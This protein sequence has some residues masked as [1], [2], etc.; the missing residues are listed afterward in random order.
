MYYRF[1]DPVI[2]AYN[3]KPDSRD[4]RKISRVCEGIW[5]VYEEEMI[6]NAV[7]DFIEYPEFLKKRL[8]V[9]R[10]S[11]YV[12]TLYNNSAIVIGLLYGDGDFMQTVRIATD[13]GFDTDCN[14]GNAGAIIGAY[15]GHDLI[16]S[17][18]KRFIR[19]EIIPGL[20][21]WSDKSLFKLS[22]RTHTQALRFDDQSDL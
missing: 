7:S 8:S 11:K 4:S 16:P 14:A 6:K 10:Y 12:H 9:T 17:Y 20:T 5:W 22:Q 3:D 21:D 18:A 13:C 19:E 15:L 1:I 2:N